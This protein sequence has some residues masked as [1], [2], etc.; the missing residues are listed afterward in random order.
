MFYLY[1]S[2]IGHVIAP[3]GASFITLIIVVSIRIRIRHQLRAV[4][5]SE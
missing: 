4:T 2:F 3:R 1:I 5:R